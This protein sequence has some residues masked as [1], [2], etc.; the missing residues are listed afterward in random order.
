MNKRWAK[1]LARQ[2]IASLVETDMEGETWLT[3]RISCLAEADRLKVVDAI[4]QICL[5]LRKGGEGD[6]RFPD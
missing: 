6:S 3:E 1:R 2:L 4:H 5:Q